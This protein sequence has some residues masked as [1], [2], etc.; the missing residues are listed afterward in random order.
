MPDPAQPTIPDQPP[1]ATISVTRTAGQIG[2]VTISGD[3][4]NPDERITIDVNDEELQVEQDVVTDNVGQFSADV[5]LPESDGQYLIT[6]TDESN[7]S[8]ST[9]YN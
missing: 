9:T 8:A 6:A 2:D 7:K 5:V 4:F 1:T 3:G